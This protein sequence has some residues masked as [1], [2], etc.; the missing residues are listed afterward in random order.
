MEVKCVWGYRWRF[1]SSPALEC[2]EELLRE[3]MVSA[4]E[5]F[6]VDPAA[7]CY[8]ALLAISC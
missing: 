7:L 4:C 3:R 2:F 1:G 6:I 5:A 8:C